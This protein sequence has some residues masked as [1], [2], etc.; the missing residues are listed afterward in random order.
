MGT[1]AALN[2]MLVAADIP[3]QGVGSKDVCDVFERPSAITQQSG[4]KTSSKLTST[5]HMVC[6]LR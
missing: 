2:P 6:L 4:I 3:N 1:A 5:S